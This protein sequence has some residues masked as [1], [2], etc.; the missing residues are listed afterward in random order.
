L[1][2]ALAVAE[3]VSAMPVNGCFYWWTAALAP[4]PMRR[5]LSF[6]S[7]WTNLLTLA[8]SVASYAFATASIIQLSVSMIHPEWVATNAQLMAIAWGTVFVWMALAAF[9]LEDIAWIY[10]GIGE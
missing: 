10:M 1:P 8:T 2:Q 3:L 9:R 5:S 6:I 7:G 4:P